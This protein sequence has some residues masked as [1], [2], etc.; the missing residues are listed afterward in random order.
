MADV[1]VVYNGRN[2]DINLDELFTPERR[3]SVGLAADTVLTSANVTEAQV[4]QALAQYYD[5]GV[6][7][8]RDFFVEINPNGNLTV[9]PNTVFG[10]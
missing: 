9:R 1:H 4:K 8:F 6:G 2:D 5:V 7:E 10:V 3:A